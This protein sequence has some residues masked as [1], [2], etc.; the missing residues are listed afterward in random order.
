MGSSPSQPLRSPT[1]KL[2]LEDLALCET[3]WQQII[4]EDYPSPDP[5]YASFRLYFYS[6]C[7][8]HLKDQLFSSQ[9]AVEAAPPRQETYPPG[10]STTSYPLTNPHA[11][12]TIII[13]FLKLLPLYFTTMKSNQPFQK[14]SK[15]L[16]LSSNHLGIQPPDLVAFEKAYLSA[17]QS[18][19]PDQAA[20][21]STW[22]LLFQHVMGIVLPECQRHEAQ[23]S[24]KRPLRVS[25][26]SHLRDAP[27]NE[28]IGYY[29]NYAFKLILST[30]KED[31]DPNSVNCR[32]ITSLDNSLDRDSHKSMVSQF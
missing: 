24:M 27:E 10:Q 16:A 4:S 11:L 31:N 18:C 30:G 21:Y 28:I 2:S 29:A 14:Y 15:S 19:F 17:I 13:F 23:T 8:K 9:T 20:I 5:N 32:L 22:S 3:T 12:H 26:G 7:Y 6:H 1:S 25:G